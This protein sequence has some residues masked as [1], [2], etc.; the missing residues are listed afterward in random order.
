MLTVKKRRLVRGT[1]LVHWAELS[2]GTD[3]DQ[4]GLAWAKL[5]HFQ[6]PRLKNRPRAELFPIPHGVILITGIIAVGMG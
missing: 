6:V 1:K 2:T 3:N 4:I 5:P